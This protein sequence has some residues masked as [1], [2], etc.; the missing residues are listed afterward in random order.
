VSSRRA[1]RMFESRISFL[2][3]K[4]GGRWSDAVPSGGDEHIVR[5]GM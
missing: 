2:S 4:R 5:W 1:F 3:R